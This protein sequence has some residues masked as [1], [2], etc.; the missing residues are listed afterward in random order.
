MRVCAEWWL[1]WK[2]AVFTYCYTENIHTSSNWQS[3]LLATM[4]FSPLWGGNSSQQSIEHYVSL[5]LP[6]SQ[7]G[8]W[9]GLGFLLEQRKIDQDSFPPHS[10]PSHDRGYLPSQVWSFISPKWPLWLGSSS[11]HLVYHSCTNE[12][13][14]PTGWTTVY[15]G[16][17]ATPWGIQ[18]NLG[19]FL[20]RERVGG[21]EH[22]PVYVPPDV[23]H[24]IG[25]HFCNC[26][27][28]IRLVS[29]L[30]HYYCC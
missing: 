24:F 19:S 16:L 3:G 15:Q 14:K 1:G 12:K 13:M 5:I 2:K 10:L 7:W 25:D 20:L 17:S 26:N 11:C 4:G 9:W 22:K 23:K 21:S 27:S 18:A 6:R 8:G 29:L 30:F 28:L